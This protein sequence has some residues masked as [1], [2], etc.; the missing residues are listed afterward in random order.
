MKAE[1]VFTMKSKP[2]VP[3]FWGIARLV[4]NKLFRRKK[5]AQ[6]SIYPLR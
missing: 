1:G 4:F 6:S 2:V 3:G 5:K